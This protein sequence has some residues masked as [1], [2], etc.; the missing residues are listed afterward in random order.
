MYSYI[1]AY[2]TFLKF[3]SLGANKRTYTPYEIAASIADDIERDPHKR[4]DKG[5]DHIRL[6][7]KSSPD[8]VTVPRDIGINKI[9]KTI[10]KYCSEYQVGEYAET[11]SETRPVINAMNNKPW[12]RKTTNNDSQRTPSSGEYKKRPIR[13]MTLTCGFCGQIGHDE[14]SD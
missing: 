1:N 14:K 13:D 3:E 9:A 2:N 11:N 5:I 4:F 7:M 8:G 12:Q 10:C 6:Q